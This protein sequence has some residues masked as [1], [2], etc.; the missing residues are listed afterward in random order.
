LTSDQGAHF[1]N[2]MIATLTRK[3][4]IKHHKS[5]PDHPQE[6]SIVEAFNKILE[7]GFTKVCCANRDDWGERVQVILWAYRTT[8][9]KLHQHTPFPLVYGKKAVVPIKFITPSLYIAD[10]TRMTDDEIVEWVVELLELEEAIFL[11]D[12][13]HIVENARKKDWHD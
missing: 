7:K 12:F 8:T 5:S 13:H 3:F 1:I 10:M 4:L 9:K 2:E 11:A 6:K